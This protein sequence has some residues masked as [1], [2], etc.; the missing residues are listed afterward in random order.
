MVRID[1]EGLRLF[2][3]HGV[4]EQE[5]TVGNEFVV[6][7]TIFYPAARAAE[8]DDIDLTLNYAEVVEIAKEEF[9][10]PSKLIENVALRIAR[11][12]RGQW[13]RI[14]SGSVSVAKLSPPI[15]QTSLSRIKVTVD[16][17]HS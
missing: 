12:L 5:R 8:T 7:I 15:P 1:I 3:R 14:D 10:I 17:P 2:G 6:D 13:P 16:I 4:L 9:E 11:R